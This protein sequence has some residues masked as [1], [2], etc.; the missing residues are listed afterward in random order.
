MVT[1]QRRNKPHPCPSLLR[2]QHQ[3]LVDRGTGRWLCLRPSPS[4]ITSVIDRSTA[5]RLS[6]PHLYQPLVFFQESVWTWCAWGSSRYMPSRC[7]RYF[8]LGSL[9]EGQFPGPGTVL[10]MVFIKNKSWAERQEGGREQAGEASGRVEGG[11]RQAMLPTTKMLRRKRRNEN[12]VARLLGFGADLAS[13]LQ[14]HNRS[15]ACD[16]RRGDDYNIPH[17]INHRWAPSALVVAR[18]GMAESLPAM[19]S[20]TVSFQDA[21]ARV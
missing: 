8:G 11:R 6:P 14:L 12:A 20:D 7:S 17:W 3:G 19:F 18:D 9:P 21:E 13:P 16:S 2:G 4:E 5:L 1:G 10:R 15:A